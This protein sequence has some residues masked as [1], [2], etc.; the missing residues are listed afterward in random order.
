[1]Q[2]KTYNMN[3]F[4]TL[5]A[6]LFITLG[7][8]SFAQD[9][10]KTDAA[11]GSKKPKKET[12]ISEVIN[13][14]SVSANVLLNRAVNWVKHETNKFDKVNG[15]TTAGK[16]ECIATFTVKPK[17]LNAQC[18]YTGVITMK[19]IIECKTGKYK[20]TINQISHKS[21][22]GKTSMGSI[23]NQIPECGSM[24][25]PEIVMK[26]LRGEALKCANIVVE[27]LKEAMLKDSLEPVEEW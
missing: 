17:E 24:T 9:K 5:I 19:V 11:A 4:K 8:H 13:T 14:D 21:K 18:D 2:S 15:V 20:Y 6:L 27:D 16:A 1:M 7:F 12:K 3:F 10:E 26:K 22:G 25:M 23:D